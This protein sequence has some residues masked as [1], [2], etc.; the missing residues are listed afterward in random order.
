MSTS[1][2][3]LT[4][5]LQQVAAIM[6]EVAAEA[7]LPRFRHLDKADI[8]AKGSGGDFATIADLEA[9]H[10]LAERL[11]PLLPGSLIVGE[12]ASAERPE[13][14]QA[15][16]G[17]APVWIVDPL[18]G[19]HNFAKGSEPFTVIVALARAGET[20]A[21]WIYDPLGDALAMAERGSG[22][23]E[24]GRRLKV[25]LAAPIEAMR[26]A[27]YCRAGRRGLSPALDQMRQKFA[28]L[29]DLRCAGAEHLALLRGELHF[30]LF[31]RLMPWDHAAGALLHSEAGGVNACFDGKLYRPT[32]HEGGLILAPDQVSWQALARLLVAPL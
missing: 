12:E 31:S 8:K 25:A 28:G 32:R 16:A 17:E 22:A 7:I 18:D 15:I 19:T 11:L 2:K 1:A 14:M 30:A 29:S 9:E 3:S 13:L 10:A 27:I 20:V 21:G 23:Y 5:D 6:R 4:V 24:A 26:G